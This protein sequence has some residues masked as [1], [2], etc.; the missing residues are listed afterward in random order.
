MNQHFNQLISDKRKSRKLTQGEI[1]DAL[2]V[3]VSFYS[4]LEMGKRAPSPQIL[5]ILVNY[6]NLDPEEERQMH[7]AAA[8]SIE[9][10]RINSKSSNFA[11]RSVAL[12]L[13]RS[14]DTLDDAKLK[15]LQEILND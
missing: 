13:A 11:A 8:R 9:Q 7:D 2:D 14:F 4:A 12:S 15:K 5:N 6:L 3:S 1:A 10:I